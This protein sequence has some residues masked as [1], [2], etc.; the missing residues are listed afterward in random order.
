RR[1]DQFGQSWQ[2]GAGPRGT[3]GFAPEV[4]FEQFI[5]ELL[6]RRAGYGT[7]FGGF[8]EVDFPGQDV[9]AALTLTWAEAFHGCQ[10]H[11]TLNG[12]PITI[13]I[14]PGAK[15]GSRVRVKGKGQP[16]PFGGQQRGDLYLTLELPPHPFFSFEG[17]DLACELP[18]T[19]DEAV[20]GATVAVPTPTGT[21]QMKIPPGVDSGQT[22]R[23]RG[24]GWRD[25]QGQRSDLRVHLKIVSPKQIS[26][27]ERE[28]YE[29]LRQ[30]R[31][32][33]PRRHVQ[34]V[35]L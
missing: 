20:L 5:N 13:R 16:S 14:P 30:Q 22:L 31:S 6:K 25:P 26:A 12:E 2:Q 4:D 34:E 15:Q 21:V 27:S 18:I 10:K 9:E 33:D 23:L 8:R 24:Q 17:D 29:K 3:A 11:F 19:P 32:W 7:G 35:R 28:L 1:Y